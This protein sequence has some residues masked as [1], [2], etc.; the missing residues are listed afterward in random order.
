MFQN[1]GA[2]RFG[3]DESG[4]VLVE[5]I[6]VI[7][8]LLT[9]SLI[10][11]YFAAIFHSMAHLER[12]S[13]IASRELSL[14]RADDETNGVLTACSAIT[15]IGAGGGVSVEQI[16]CDLAERSIGTHFVMA[17]DGTSDG[18][19]SEGADAFVQLVVPE[20]SLLPFGV[21]PSADDGRVFAARSTLRMQQLDSE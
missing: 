8:V 18:F 2:Q 17:S 6:L 16:A 19:G 5:T 7:P 20:S 21:S 11:I 12:A 14:G 15:G 3:R 9:I 10:I 4:V 1:P 13:R